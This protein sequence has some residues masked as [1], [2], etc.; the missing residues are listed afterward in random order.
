MDATRPPKDDDDGRRRRPDVCLLCEG[1]YPYIAGGVSSWVHDIIEGEPQVTFSV[2]NIGSHPGWHGPSKF[3][4]PPNVTALEDLYCQDTP[5]AP[6]DGPEKAALE[7]DIRRCRR[8]A[9]RRTG[10]SRLLRG[11]RRLHLE[12]GV[13]DQLLADLASADLSVSELIYGRESF[14]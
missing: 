3:E 4:L 9:A 1:T 14:A 11:L 6:I 5:P 13:D 12:D 7:R 2:L 10:P 8:R